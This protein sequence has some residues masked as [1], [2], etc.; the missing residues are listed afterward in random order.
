MFVVVFFHN[1]ISMFGLSFHHLLT[2]FLFPLQ[3]HVFAS[4]FYEMLLH[5]F[6]VKFI[7]VSFLFLFL[8]NGYYFNEGSY[9]SC[10]N[11]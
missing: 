3:V 9:I 2:I 7:L 4:V 11:G 1:K 5:L 6:V 8:H 10:C